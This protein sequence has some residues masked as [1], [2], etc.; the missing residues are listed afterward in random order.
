MPIELGRL[1][2]AHD[3]RGVLTREQRPG[4]EPVL[5]SRGPWPDLLFVEIVV[6]GQG[7]VAKVARERGPAV[8]GP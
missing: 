1:D 6:D 2:Q 4:E 5:A 7:G 3:G 8:Q